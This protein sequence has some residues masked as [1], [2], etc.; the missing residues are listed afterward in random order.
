MQPESP[1]VASLTPAEFRSRLTGTGLGLRVG[2]FDLCVQARVAGLYEPLQT[3]Y[4]GYPVLDHHHVF[5]AQEVS[6]A[7]AEAER[8]SAWLVTTEKD[9]ER[10]PEGTADGLVLDVSVIRGELPLPQRRTL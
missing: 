1:R 6:A 5:S 3:L 2:P 4:S 9:A 8:K 10:L 7:T